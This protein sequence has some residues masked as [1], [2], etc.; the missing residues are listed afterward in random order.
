MPPPAPESAPWTRFLPWVALG[1]GA[2]G[3]LTGIG[4]GST[5]GSDECMHSIA[6]LRLFELVR[7]GD[8]SG[9][10]REFHKPEFYTPL[11][12]LGMGLG[13]L[14]GLEFDAPRTAT[15]WAWILTAGLCIPLT[16]RVAGGGAVATLAS[17]LCVAMMLGSWLAVSY[18]RAA[19]L[20]GW[21]AAITL[22]ALGAYLKARDGDSRWWSITCGLLLGMAILVKTTYGLFA[23]GAVGLSG[24]CDLWQ[25]PEGVAPVALARNVF[26]GAFVCLGWWFVLPLPLGFDYG[27]HHRANFV[28]YL[29]KAGDLDSPGPG[30]ILVAWAFMACYSL[31]IFAAQVAGLAWGCKRWSCP[32]TRLCAILGIVG[33]LAF[34]LYPFRIDRFLIP[35]LFGGCVLG[36]TILARFVLRPQGAKQRGL[37]MGLLLLLVFA[38]SS[39]EA[40]LGPGRRWANP[41][42]H[43]S[44]PASGPLGTQA[45]LNQSVSH[46]NAYVPFLWIGGTGTE[47]PPTLVDWT[48]YQ[49]QRV[50]EVLFKNRDRQAWF[51]EE[52]TGA[53][54]EPWTREEFQE[55]T[56]SYFHVLV[57]DPP[58][59]RSRPREFEQRYA[60]WMTTHPAFELLA[61]ETGAL[62][63]QPFSVRIYQKLR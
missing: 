8:W 15:A 9:F 20:E 24:L 14:G 39:L 31:P 45:L 55:Y 53:T 21:S 3:L 32:A 61:T 62:D 5:P 19:F 35:T 16:R 37:R 43:R 23:L 13:F 57:L 51:W 18:C 25:R 52:P 44:A 46:L 41:F 40:A 47:L 38:S 58:D 28:E 22:L 59:P 4:A 60:R 36:S 10:W 56:R 7:L 34:V 2:Y 29:T 6:A 63:G 26:L 27:A 30:F 33:P 11:G 48:L 42:A 54:G 12:R 49:S 50:P 1:L 17:T